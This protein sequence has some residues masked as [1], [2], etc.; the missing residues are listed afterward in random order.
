MEI[1][2]LPLEPKNVGHILCNLNIESKEMHRCYFWK[3]NGAVN[4]FHIYMTCCHYLADKYIYSYMSLDKKHTWI[5]TQP[6]TQGG[7][8]TEYTTQIIQANL[9]LKSLLLKPGSKSHN[10]TA[11]SLMHGLLATTC[12]AFGMQQQLQCNTHNFQVLGKWCAVISRHSWRSGWC[13][14]LLTSVWT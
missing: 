1:R 12:K 7:S 11:H 9:S 13:L 4:K 14:L 6:Q 8:E 5:E 2:S 3:K 10:T